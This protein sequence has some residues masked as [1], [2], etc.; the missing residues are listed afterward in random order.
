MRLQ[1][2]TIR[3][4]L[5]GILIAFSAGVSTSAPAGP[6]PAGGAP[7]PSPSDAWA[8]TLVDSRCR[9]RGESPQAGLAIND[10]GLAH[11][12]Y[13]G[14]HVNAL[15]Y[16]QQG[17]DGWSV[18]PVIT[19]TAGEIRAPVDLELDSHGYPHVLYLERTQPPLSEA[20]RYARWD[21][22]AWVTSTVV[23]AGH[24][25][26][27]DLALDA[28]DQ[29]RV[30]YGGAIPADAGRAIVRYLELDQGAWV[31]RAS[32]SH[33]YAAHLGR[34]VIDQQGRS[35]IALTQ[36]GSVLYGI[37][38]GGSLAL[39]TVEAPTP[40]LPDASNPGL[41]LA[42]DGTPHLA[43]AI[44]GP[45]GKF[46]PMAISLHY[47][48]KVGGSWQIETPN[49]MIPSLSARLTL[50]ADG[51]PHIIAGTLD[52]VY[53]FVRVAN[54]QWIARLVTRSGLA[55]LSVA[56]DPQGNTRMAYCQVAFL[57]PYVPDH[58]INYAFQVPPRTF[59]PVIQNE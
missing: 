11:L 2:S 37:Y 56:A 6:T 32:V 38:E 47:A 30:A 42:A 36:Q 49:T 10:T 24:I 22:A 31:E 52:G 9:D 48:T 3:L 46:G 5:I 18:T 4:F 26:V 55:W 45:A 39:E 19:P 50:G 23:P 41:V 35:H 34:L 16:A 33:A 25:R 27:V 44:I 53:S 8:V 14:D 54:N 12:A 1:V 57:Q 40:D 15:I 21:G 51:Q 28:Q 58:T 29:P 13:A 20:L 7:P 59:L 43:Y 17:A